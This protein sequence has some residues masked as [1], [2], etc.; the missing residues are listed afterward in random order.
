MKTGTNPETFPAQVAKDAVIT[1]TYVPR[2]DLT[3]TVNYVDEDGNAVE[4][5]D[6]FNGQTFGETV[7]ASARSVNGYVLALGQ[8]STKRI[9]IG[10]GEN[11]ITFVYTRDTMT[12]PTQPVSPENPAGDGIPDK[13]QITVNFAAVNGTVSFSSA[14]ITKR[15]ANGDPSEDGTARL[16]QQHIPTAEAREGYR[17]GTWDKTPEVGR[18]VTDGE[19]LTITYTAAPT[20]PIIPPPDPGTGGGGTPIPDTPTPLDPGTDI[21]DEE[22]PLANAVGLNDTDHFAYVIGYEDDTVR[23]LNNITRAEAVTIFFRLM[24]DEYRAANWSTENTFSDVNA[25]N[26]FNNAV[27]TVQ[28]VGALEHFAQDEKFLPN[29]AIT[30]A[31][32][33]SIAA[34]FVDSAITGETVGDFS[35]TEGHWAAEAIR[36]AVEAGWIR[37]VGGNRFAPDQTITRAE[38]MA[39]IN[40]MLDRVPDADHMLPDMK[41]WTDNPEDAW[42]YA[43]VQEA[44]NEH[45]YER[46]E[47]S[48][49]TWTLIKEHRDWVALETEWAANGGTSAPVDPAQPVEGETGSETET[50]DAE[51]K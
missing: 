49:E 30:R 50:A 26:W 1:V 4:T 41:K 51:Q 10:T 14:V 22:V 13:Y 6:T 45:D 40:R 44:T 16:A 8:E 28:K 32:F 48:V 37:G 7:A 12:D 9:E 38:V 20:D 39:M 15:D 21:P 43:D 46:D 17:N 2:T 34:G 11:T 25:G 27:S 33:A 5:P 42:Y 23:P 31:E 47:M 36:K 3:Y 18:V 29:Q 24:T 35:D 19:T